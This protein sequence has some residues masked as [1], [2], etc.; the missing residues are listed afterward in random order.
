[1][2]NRECRSSPVQS[3]LR[4]LINGRR[5]AIRKKPVGTRLVGALT[6]TKGLASWSVAYPSRLPDNGAQKTT[7]AWPHLTAKSAVQQLGD[8]L[9]RRAPE[10]C[11]RWSWHSLTLLDRHA[12]SEVAR[13]VDVSALGDRRVVGQ[14][15]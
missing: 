10:K 1:M 14:Q 15:L 13:L 11:P 9:A 8:V 12:L 5:D 7:L 2:K 4:T 6:E 3:S